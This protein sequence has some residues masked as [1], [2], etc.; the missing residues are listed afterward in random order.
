[1]LQEGIL[2]KYKKKRFTGITE[3]KKLTCNFIVLVWF[4]SFPGR[5][6]KLLNRFA[7]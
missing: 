3:G 5:V 7:R 4:G 2:L 6:N 1:M